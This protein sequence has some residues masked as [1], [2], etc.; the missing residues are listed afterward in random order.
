MNPLPRAGKVVNF[1]MKDGDVRPLLVVRVWDYSTPVSL[2]H[3]APHTSDPALLGRAATRPG[4]QVKFPVAHDPS[5]GQGNPGNLCGVLYIDPSRDANNIPG[6]PGPGRA[7]TASIEEATRQRIARGLAPDASPDEVIY[8]EQAQVPGGPAAVPARDSVANRQTLEK[9]VACGKAPNAKPAEV[10]AGQD[11]QAQLDRLAGAP[12]LPPPPEGAAPRPDHLGGLDYREGAAG[13]RDRP[14]T[15]VKSDIGDVTLAG[16]QNY[17]PRN[18]G[19]TR[20]HYAPRTGNDPK[21]GL[22][23]RDSRRVESGLPGSRL[24]AELGPDEFQ[25]WIEAAFYDD[26]AKAPGTWHWPKGR[27]H[28]G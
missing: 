19:S 17:D 26:T 25:V 12:G 18:A 28:E 24:A 11:A 9:A 1:V 3:Q 7:R 20:D 22:D 23:F 14:A 2:G 6:Q 13:R 4:E 8:M 15:D 27:A 16:D 10:A 21:G 5:A